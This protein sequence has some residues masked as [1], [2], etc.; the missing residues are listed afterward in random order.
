MADHFR[1][2]RQLLALSG[3]SFEDELRRVHTLIHFQSKITSF[4][5][6]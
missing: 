2:M 1:L 3:E 5:A 4:S 6:N